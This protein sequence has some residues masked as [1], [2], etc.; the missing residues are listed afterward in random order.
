ME[1]IYSLLLGY[2]LGSLSPSALVAKLKKVDL[3]SEGTQSLGASNTMLVIGK[4]Y[5]ALV[6]V[7]DIAKAYAAS[8]IS[9]ALFPSLALASLLA[10]L[11]AVIGHV[12]PFYLKFRGGKGLAAFGGM[13]MAY[14]P[15]YF[16]ALLCFGLLLMLIANCSY[17]MPM[18]A[19][20]L[21]PILVLVHSGS[22]PFFLIA[23]AASAIIAVKHWSNIE[24]GRS[25]RDLN[26]RAFIKELLHIG[27]PTVF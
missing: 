14:D 9:E 5:G 17:V 27:R 24:K 8:K 12:F 10:G 4:V 3:K 2:L 25:G 13:A 26:I 11:G 1:W 18:L 23:V 22:I 16:V 6:M 19:A 21:F 7:F 20:A 15:W